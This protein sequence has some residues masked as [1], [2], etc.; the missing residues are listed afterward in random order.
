MLQLG[1][2]GEEESLAM[3]IV[4]GHLDQLEGKRYDRI[5]RDLD[6][7]V[8]Q[9]VAA[10]GTISGLEP[11]PGRNFGE[12]D[13]RYITPDVFVQKVGDEYVIILNEEGLPRLR[14]SQFYRSVLG[15]D[16]TSEAKRYIQEKMRAAAWLIKSIQQRQRTLSLVTASIVKFQRDFLDHGV[17]ALKPMVLK[18]VAMDIGM[19]E[20]TVSR[21]TA[22]K[23]VHTAQGIFELKY[24]FTSSLRAGDGSDEFSA[25][26]VKERIRDIIG[27][28]SPKS[29]LSDQQIAEM[30]GKENVDI[31]RRTVAKYREMMGILPSSKRRQVF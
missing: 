4:A 24:F 18:D 6:V 9:V 12:G 2:L 26:S 11:K 13:V 16:G 19:H 15:S 10:A 3:K 29:P 7:T 14:V 17:S 27:K 21:A 30:L 8:E 31:A 5:A 25:E 20:S 22:N 23:Y 28:E 1:A